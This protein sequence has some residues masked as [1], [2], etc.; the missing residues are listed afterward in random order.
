MTQAVKTFSPTKAI[1]F[2]W[3][4]VKK[5]LFF[6]MGLELTVG[7]ISYIPGLLNEQFK[8][9]VLLTF[10]I[11]LVS[12]FIRMAISLGLIQIM[13][14]VVS[15]KKVKFNDLFSQF[16]FNFVLRYIASSILAGLAIIGGLILLIIPGIYIANRLSMI[17]YVFVDKKNIGPID[18]IKESWRITKGN[19][20]NL[21]GFGLLSLVITLVG[22][23]ALFVGVLVAAAV[24]GVAGAYIYKTLSRSK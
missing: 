8:E 16:D 5:R 12:W 7:L 4:T 23:L 20:W 13:L 11:S 6:F 3:D 15:A 10:L 9:K 2:G 21:V 18:A 14:N 1:R 24:S 22:V 19:V 17:G